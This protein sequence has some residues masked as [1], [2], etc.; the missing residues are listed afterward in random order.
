[1]MKLTD[2]V[3][4]LGIKKTAQLCAKQERSKKMRKT[5][6]ET[7]FE[8]KMKEFSKE[9]EFEAAYNKA[10][11]LLKK[12]GHHLDLIPTK[13]EFSKLFICENLIEMISPLQKLGVGTSLSASCGG[14]RGHGDEN[15]KIVLLICES[16][17]FGHRDNYALRHSF[18]AEKMYRFNKQAG[19]VVTEEVDFRDHFEAR[20]LIP[21]EYANYLAAELQTSLHRFYQIENYVNFFEKEVKAFSFVLENC[22]KGIKDL[23]NKRINAE[24]FVSLLEEFAER[25]I[26]YNPFDIKKEILNYRQASGF[27]ANFEKMLKEVACNTSYYHEVVIEQMK[28]AIKECKNNIIILGEFAEKNVS[29]I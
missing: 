11:E 25:G 18:S 8:K 4:T 27:F 21:W 9:K 16:K 7:K 15:L 1:M 14:D 17:N 24:N 10:V 26:S 20:W 3:N 12:Y 6:F 29:R 13:E 5:K 2:A 19:A 22:A 28:T 23:G